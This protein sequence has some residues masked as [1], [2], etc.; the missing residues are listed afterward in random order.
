[1]V[2]DVENIFEDSLLSLF[3]HYPVAISTAGPHEP[4]DYAPSRAPLPRSTGED[5][6][7]VPALFSNPPSGPTSSSIPKPLQIYLPVAPSSL[8]T[9]LQ[10]THLWLS[11]LYMADLISSHH[12]NLP[13][14]NQRVCELGAGAGLPG[15]AALVHGEAREVVGT[16]YAVPEHEREE[17]AAD[18]DA[19]AED[20]LGVLRGNYRRAIKGQEDHFTGKWAVTGHTWGESTVPLLEEPKPSASIPSENDDRLFTTLLLADLLWSSSSHTS[21]ITSLLTLLHPSR[22]VAH[23]ISGLH[24]GRG[25]VERFKALWREMNTGGEAWIK[26]VDEV[27]WGKSGWERYEKEGGEREREWNSE[28]ERGVIVWFVVGTTAESRA[29]Y[30]RKI[31]PL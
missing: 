18:A 16:D 26:E 22:G 20:V 10:L 11:S 31:I 7:E 13:T 29:E 14:R 9:T 15:I 28:N 19:D 30:E 23:V 12:P 6:H 2:Q 24:Q 21:L 17:G 1:M 5:D 4:Y 27:R 8:H 3:D 25:P